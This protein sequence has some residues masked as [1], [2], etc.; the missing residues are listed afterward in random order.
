MVLSS[1]FIPLYW[2]NLN[3][4]K[5]TIYIL[6]SLLFFTLKIQA[7][8]L[9]KFN[10]LNMDNG[11]SDN[12][13]LS[14]TKGPEGFLWFGSSNGLNKYDGKTIKVFKISRNTNNII[15]RIIPIGSNFLFI[16]SHNNLYLFNKRLEKFSPITFRNEKSEQGILDFSIDTNSQCWSITKDGLYRIDLSQ[17]KIDENSDT[18]FLRNEKIECPENKLKI[19]Y[20]DQNSN[21]TFLATSDGQVLSLNNENKKVQYICKIPLKKE[22]GIY[23]LFYDMGQLWITTL[24]EGIFLYDMVSQKL[25]HWT[26]P[27]NGS[28]D[29]LSHNDVYQ[30]LP[31]DEGKYLA[32][33]WNGYT[34]FERMDDNTYQLQAYHFPYSQDQ[35]AETRMKTGFYDKEGLIWIGTEG[36]GILYADLREVFY[37]QYVQKHANEICSILMDNKNYIWLT[38]FN[39]GIMRSS[40]AFDFK[41][42]LDFES[43]NIP[44]FNTSTFLSGACYTNNKLWFGTSNGNLIRINP[45]NLKSWEYI[46]LHHPLKLKT[47]IWSILPISDDEGYASTESGLFYINWKKYESE[48]IDWG[49]SIQE[50]SISIRAITIDNSKRLWLGTYNGLVMLQPSDNSHNKYYHKK[51]YEEYFDKSITYKEI[52]ALYKDSNNMLWIGYQGLGLAKLSLSE[53][54]IVNLYTTE[55]GLCSNFTSAITEDKNQYIWIGSNSGISRI[56]KHLNSFYNYYISGSNRSVYA[57]NGVLFWGNHSMLTYFKPQKLNIDYTA[58][59]GKVYFTDL[60]INHVPVK[61]N[62]TINNQIILKEALNYTK[63][64]KLNYENRNFS[65]SFTNLSYLNKQQKYLY[66]LSPYQKDWIITNEANKISYVNVPAGEYTFQVKTIF[67]NQKVGPLCEMKFIITPHWSETVWFRLII[68]C[69]VFILIIMAIRYFYIKQKRKQHELKLEHELSI[70]KMERD[71]E[72]ELRKERES[73]FTTTAHELRTPLT[74]IISPLQDLLNRINS[75]HPFYGKLSLILKYALGLQ[76]QTD[77]LLYI[78]KIEAGMVKLQLSEI[79]INHL[80]DDIAQDFVILAQKQNINYEYKSI[81]NDIY[82]WGDREKLSSVIQNLISNSFKYTPTEGHIKVSLSKKEIDRQYFVC[83]EIEDSGCGIDPKIKETI[84]NSYE[85]GNNTPLF[86]SS[87]GLG[88]KI[89]KSIT[90][91]HHGQILVNS[92]KGHGTTFF[93][94]IP[95]G[96]EH[97]KTDEYCIVRTDEHIKNTDIVPTINVSEKQDS[98]TNNYKRGYTVLIIEDNKDMRQYVSSIFQKSYKVLQAEN[99]EIGLEMAIKHNPDIIIS[100]VMMPVMDGLEF[101]SQLRSNQ[102]I[103]QIPIIMLT[104]KSEDEDYI[105]AS[106]SGADDYIRKPFNPEVLLSKTK[107]LLK[108]RRQLKQI[109]TKALL[110]TPKQ[111]TEEDTET[112]IDPFMQQIISCIEANISNSDFNAKQLADIMNMSQATLYRK[113]KKHTDLT[114]VELIRNMRM[115]QAALLLTNSEYSIVEIAERVGFNDLPTFRKHFTDMFGTSP[116]KYHESHSEKL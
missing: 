64:V 67:Q 18:I 56:S 26:S 15:S 89:A 23:S 12:T 75:S 8:D 115:T 10:V 93:V 36:G 99:G 107:H 27:K 111:K 91:M 45:T 78:Q 108:M 103:A 84:F 88:L 2:I 20:T 38:T 86:S 68:T 41:K 62:D 57:K 13:I 83:I 92:E 50:S 19:I 37:K 31:F 105:Q 42:R 44:L 116:S 5:N 97:F 48:F 100:D 76:T 63:T 113:L 53:D 69:I 39:K 4:M 72:I 40:E 34:I 77:R 102:Q 114:A 80:L 28:S 65:I 6:L 14:I 29:Q 17:I 32:L 35:Y 55:D 51:G 58:Q 11:L 70:A 94:Y 52:R 74:L 21:N 47:N 60:E 109:Y 16:L 85:T 106:E 25:K 43:I 104:A 54:K 82:I 95:L 73:F 90:E 71:Q 98:E 110:N 101:C 87:I 9:L 30:I 1:F 66:R 59:Q 49:K 33:T 46:S 22:L 79:N 24:E 96:K 3:E 61:I 7:Q 112:N 81:D